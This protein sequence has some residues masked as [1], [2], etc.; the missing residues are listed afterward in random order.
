[1]AARKTSTQGTSI[2][3]LAQVE[4]YGSYYHSVIDVGGEPSRY[5][6]GMAMLGAGKDIID[7]QKELAEHAENVAVPSGSCQIAEDYD[8]S[9]HDD[10]TDYYTARVNCPA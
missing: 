10:G 3:Q 5:Q 2:D 6:F 1:M 7:V 9:G 4:Q 8:P